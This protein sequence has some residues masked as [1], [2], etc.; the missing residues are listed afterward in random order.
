MKK[1]F[2]KISF[3]IS[4]FTKVDP[5]SLLKKKKRLY[6]G[7]GIIAVLIVAISLTLFFSLKDTDAAWWNDN[8]TYRRLVPVTNNTVE[9]SNVYIAI[10]IDTSDTDKFQGDCGDLRFTD[11]GGSLLKYYISSGCATA[12]T[13]ITIVLVVSIVL[14]FN[15]SKGFQLTVA[16]H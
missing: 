16:K 3:N 12:T 1:L 6:F 10:T 9:E 7:L 4:K 8:W 14:L 5:R 2:K 13:V 15:C 11:Y